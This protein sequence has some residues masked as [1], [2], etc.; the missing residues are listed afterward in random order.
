MSKFHSKLS[1]ESFYAFRPIFNG[2]VDKVRFPNG[3]KYEGF[4]DQDFSYS[5]VTGG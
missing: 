1:V 3:L 2:T 5:T 4:G